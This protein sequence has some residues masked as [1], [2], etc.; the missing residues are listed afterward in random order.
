MKQE[1]RPEMKLKTHREEKRV[2]VHIIPTSNSR[3]KGE[4][5]VQGVS[6]VPDGEGKMIRVMRKAQIWNL[7]ESL[8]CTNHYCLQAEADNQQK[9]WQK[10]VR[11]H[12]SLFCRC[13]TTPMPIN[14]SIIFVFKLYLQKLLHCFFFE[15]SLIKAC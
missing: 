13:T 8:H 14:N 12:I 10:N 7:Y 2:N 9:K 4:C 5:T 3:P 6:S 1:T 15:C 11:N